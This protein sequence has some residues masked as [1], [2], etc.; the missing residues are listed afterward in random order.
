M[1]TPQSKREV[2]AL[3][4]RDFAGGTYPHLIHNNRR[5]LAITDDDEN[6]VGETL[7]RHEV[8]SVSHDED[9][10]GWD[11]VSA[12]FEEHGGGY[13]PEYGVDHVSASDEEHGSDEEYDIPGNVTVGN[14]RAN[15]VLFAVLLFYAVVFAVASLIIV[16]LV[17]GLNVDWELHQ[18]LW[19]PCTT[20][21]ELGLTEGSNHECAHLKFNKFFIL[22]KHLA[23][24]LSSQRMRH[25]FMVIF[26]VL[27]AI[28]FFLSRF[29]SDRF[30]PAIMTVL[31]TV[32]RAIIIARNEASLP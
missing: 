8:A 14:A 10:S 2:V 29:Y 16:L 9:G 4:P 28:A 7:S 18:F 27:V 5:V 32:H 1:P 13:Y 20:D 11:H 24:A 30:R 6:E 15:A 22:L 17:E 19:K 23:E 26:I 31:R 3:Y 21:P 12:S 25:E